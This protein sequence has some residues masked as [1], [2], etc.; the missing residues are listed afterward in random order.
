MLA[1]FRCVCFLKDTVTD[2]V[3]FYVA[4]A[5]FKV[6]ILLLQSLNSWDYRLLSQVWLDGVS[7]CLIQHSS[8]KNY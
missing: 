4:Q 2:T 6:C 1:T 7:V 8:N 5:G 3:A